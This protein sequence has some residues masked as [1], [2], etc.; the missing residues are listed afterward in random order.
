MPKQKYN[1]EEIKQ[2]FFDSEYTEVKGFLINKWYTYDKMS[3][4]RT[5]GRTK[6]K[7]EHKKNILNKTQEGEIQVKIDYAKRREQKVQEAID[8]IIDDIIKR[9]KNTENRKERVT[10][11]EKLKEDIGEGKKMILDVNNTSHERTEEDKAIL[12]KIKKDLWLDGV[13]FS[14]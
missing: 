7:K 2:E 12:D 10:Y 14:D 9:V 3:R 13:K 4:M 11:L 6:E 1:R 5:K 8:W